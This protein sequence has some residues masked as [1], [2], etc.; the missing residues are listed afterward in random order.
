MGT[1]RR[2]RYRRL[3]QS[4]NRPGEITFPAVGLSTPSLIVPPAGHRSPGRR[5]VETSRDDHRGWGQIHLVA[6][7]TPPPFRREAGPNL[8][9]LHAA[10]TQ[11]PG[12]ESLK[13]SMCVAT[14]RGDDSPQ[15]LDKTAGWSHPRT[16]G[17]RPA[18]RTVVKLL[19]ERCQIAGGPLTR[20]RNLRAPLRRLP[21][22]SYRVGGGVRRRWLRAPAGG[23]QGVLAARILRRARDDKLSASARA[24]NAG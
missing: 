15:A 10:W 7:P 4:L 5:T 19:V 3:R 13:H 23:H 21:G 9:L 2:C 18:A 17:T 20:K 6:R 11:S 8:A 16:R 24:R 14:A 22:N 1:F 12:W